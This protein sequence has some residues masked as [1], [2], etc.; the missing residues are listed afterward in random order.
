MGQGWDGTIQGKD[1]MGAIVLIYVGARSKSKLI[2]R[3]RR[4]G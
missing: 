2:C 3:A 1:A 4:F